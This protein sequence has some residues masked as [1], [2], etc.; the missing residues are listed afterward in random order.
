GWAFCSVGAPCV[1]HLVCPMPIRPA[2]G[3]KL[4]FCARLPSLPSARRREI[5]PSSSVATPALSYPRYSRRL[6]AST[7]RTATGS[8]PTMPT[9][10]HMLSVLLCLLARQL[11]GCGG[12]ENF[13]G[14]TWLV[15]LMRAPQGQCIGFDIPGDD[16]AAR[17]QRPRSHGHWCH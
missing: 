16:A 6:S 1:A 8:L 4:S 7:K 12:C 5:S 15:H 13:L 2:S 11:L 14:P 10:P 17:D 9:I 3:S